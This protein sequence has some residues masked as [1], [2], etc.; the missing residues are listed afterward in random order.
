M[1][2]A[3]RVVAVLHALS[4]IVQPVLAG[5]FLSG[6]DTAVDM[7]AT[8]G[9][10]VVTLCLVM[11]ILAFPVWRRGLLPRA[12][13]TTSA[14]LLVVEVIQMMVGFTHI[15]WL[16]IPLGVLMMGGVAQLMPLVMRPYRPSAER[17]AAAGAVVAFP[18]VEAGE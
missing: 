9:M 16:H 12:A 1:L 4:F 3:L 2:P 6:Q 15:M 7:H 14:A 8:N 18:A 11:T 13:F 10:I 17:A 5:L